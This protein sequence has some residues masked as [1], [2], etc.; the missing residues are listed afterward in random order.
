MLLYLMLCFHLATLGSLRA[1]SKSLCV[2][3]DGDLAA[4]IDVPGRDEF[5]AMGRE[6]ESMATKLSSIVAAVRN[7]ASLVAVAGERVSES[8]RGLAR[9]TEEQAA[10][11]G[12]TTSTMRGISSAV[13]H[14]ADVA[15]QADA[16]MAELRRVGEAGAQAMD[17]A[18]EKMARIE[19]GAARVA[20]IVGTIDAIA[21]QTNLLA[22]NAAVEAARAG[23]HG[24][25]FAVVA[26][27]VRQ[28]AQRAATSAH[29]IRDLI[30]GSRDEAAEG[31]RGVRAIAHEMGQLLAGVREVGD[32]LR[33]VAQASQ[34]QSRGL[35][36]VAAAVGNLDQLTQSNAAAVEAA[37]ATASG[38]LTRSRSLSTV[39][40][41]MRLRQGTADEAREFVERAA[42]L[43]RERGWQAAHAELHAAGNPFSDRDLY[44]FAFD[45]Q[46]IYRAFSSNRA[47][48]GQPLS[49]VPGLDA[50]RLVEDAWAAV[51]AEGRGWI[52]Y[53]IVNPA[54]G[55]VT[56]KS[57]YVLGI[58]AQLL[59]GC[60]VYRNVS[61]AAA[62]G[63]PA[64][65]PKRPVAATPPPSLATA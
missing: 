63:R 55:A 26:A 27:E 32:R 38:L 64:L 29:E 61:V 44:V 62:A 48:V 5:A 20:E 31:A 7:D 10:S 43:V 37:A 16:R 30:S 34:Q 25:G 50:K 8:S 17:Q 19:Q 59:L 11:L 24:K 33:E 1:V 22:L 51:D 41:H 35:D 65:A 36:N 9:R 39:V 45:R 46:G 23:E 47:K 6:L 54:T 56:P 13:S 28:L 60:G 18:V 14:H 58:D 21:F 12:Q 57:S 15:T 42:A 2:L 49:S 40:S 4:P 53:D 52:D 3:A